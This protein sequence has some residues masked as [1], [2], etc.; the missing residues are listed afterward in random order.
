[1]GLLFYADRSVAVVLGLVRPL[2]IDV[3]VLGLLLG[4]LGELAAERLHVDAGHLLVEVL[5]QAVDLVV[6]LVAL[7]PQFDLRS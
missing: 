7:R 5:G 6:V 4:E 2:D 1:M 3:D